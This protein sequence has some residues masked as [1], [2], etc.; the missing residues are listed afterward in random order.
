[1]AKKGGATEISSD[2]VDELIQILAKERKDFTSIEIAETLW[3]ALKI[4]PAA[5][6][7]HDETPPSQSKEGNV[8]PELKGNLGHEDVDSFDGDNEENEQSPPT[9]PIT[10]KANI[11]TPSPKAGVLPPKTLP[12]WIADPN[13][14]GD[15]LAVIRALK[16]L[17]RKVR[18]QRRETFE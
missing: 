8:S 2:S 9:K 13:F 16:P 7:S 14:L 1:M 15:S 4:E 12:I 6:A 17:L 10:P 5:E 3:L 11:A 18:N